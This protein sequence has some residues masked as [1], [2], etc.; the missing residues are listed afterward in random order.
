MNPYAQ[1]DQQNTNVFFFVVI[2][3]QK[4]NK[5]IIH[6]LLN[7]LKDKCDH[8][9]YLVEVITRPTMIMSHSLRRVV[10]WKKSNPNLVIKIIYHKVLK[11]NKLK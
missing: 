7:V 3:W 8:I 5:E 6:E 1:N 2:K 4:I 10:Y 9:V 11:I